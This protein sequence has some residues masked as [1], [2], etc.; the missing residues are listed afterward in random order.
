MMGKSKT[1]SKNEAILHKN[2]FP[3][4]PFT[5][6]EVRIKL[7][8]HGFI[9][10]TLDNQEYALAGSTINYYKNINEIWL[11]RSDLKG[12]KRSL[13][14]IIDWGLNNLEHK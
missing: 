12:A 8:L 2:E 3:Y 1:N 7:T 11:D 10:I 4:W 6:N 14:T 9:I 13:T 5:V